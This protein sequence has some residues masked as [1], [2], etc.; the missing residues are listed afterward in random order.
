LAGQSGR[1]HARNALHLVQQVRSEVADAL[2]RRVIGE[3]QGQ[4][5]REHVRSVEAHVLGIEPIEA[6]AH[7]RRRGQHDE[8]QRELNDE[9][10][11]PAPLARTGC[12]GLVA[13]FLQRSVDVAASEGSGRSAER[14][15]QERD[16][17][18][19]QQH[20]GVHSDLRGERRVALREGREQ[21]N[22]R[23]RDDETGEAA[24][25]RVGD[26][27]RQ[28]LPG[29]SRWR[30]SERSA[31]G[32]L[33]APRGGSREIQIRHVRARDQHHEQRDAE[34][35]HERRGG[36]AD[37]LALES[38]KA[39]RVTVARRVSVGMLRDEP[40]SDHLELAARGGDAHTVAQLGEH[41]RQH[42]N[43][44]SRG[45]GSARA[46]RARRARDPDVVVVRERRNDRQH[47]DHLVRRIVHL[48]D[49]SHDAGIGPELF[50]PECVR[51]QDRGLRAFALVRIHEGAAEQRRHAQHVEVLPAHHAGLN[52][53]GVAVAEQREAHPVIFGQL[54]VSCG[55]RPIVEK[56]GHGPRRVGEIR[57]GLVLLDS[58]E[59]IAVAIGQ[60]REQHAV[61]DAEH[62]A[63]RPDAERE[64]QHD[65]DGR[66]GA[67]PGVAPR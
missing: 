39:R 11:V 34:Q 48:E 9:Q 53:I 47:A 6:Q 41:P 65:Q 63:V 31:N 29:D 14:A 32:E 24:R 4:I 67:L 3:V 33:L 59:P 10:Q 51:Q 37:H 21:M 46:K 57:G 40:G 8:R 49:V 16:G 20:R 22:A 1:A 43:L 44:T 35:Q 17:E 58:H 27:F 56:R 18:R 55:L 28:H 50:G 5:H 12:G 19:A 61:G 54:L 45:H 2:R 52:E 23:V 36:V 42:R 62:G 38:P 7:Q 25:E 60:R 66:E 64:R 26:A 30:G 13:A 15:C